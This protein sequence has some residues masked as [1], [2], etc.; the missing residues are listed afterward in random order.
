MHLFFLSFA[1]QAHEMPEWSRYSCVCINL[2]SFLLSWC[3]LLYDSVW[4]LHHKAQG[5]FYEN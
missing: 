1:T 5:V 3:D 4:L 2:H